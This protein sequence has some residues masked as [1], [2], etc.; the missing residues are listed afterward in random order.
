LLGTRAM[1]PIANSGLES[2]RPN[3]PSVNP[4]LLLSG[5]S[6]GGYGRC[7]LFVQELALGRIIVDIVQRAGAG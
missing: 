1:W 4:A 7:Q 3:S 5:T 2:Y 6:V